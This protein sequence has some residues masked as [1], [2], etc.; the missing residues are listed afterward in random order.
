[1]KVFLK[2]VKCNVY[3]LDIH[4]N[5]CS[6]YMLC[7]IVSLIVFFCHD[8]EMCAKKLVDVKYDPG[9]DLSGIASQNATQITDIAIERFS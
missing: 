5:I 6:P 3:N 7:I 1:M 9:L 8:A 4:V 2:P